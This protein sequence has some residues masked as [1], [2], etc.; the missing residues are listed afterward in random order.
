MTDPNLPANGPAA[1]HYRHVRTITGVCGMIAGIALFVLIQELRSTTAAALL[2]KG[3][4]T[5]AT[6]LPSTLQATYDLIIPVGVPLF[7][8][9]MG[10]QLFSPTAFGQV[11]AAV[12][13]LLP[14]TKGP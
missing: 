1:L 3:C 12:R 13:S 11:V 10:V 5:P 2:A 7:I 4:P 6:V 9:V 8:V 14:W